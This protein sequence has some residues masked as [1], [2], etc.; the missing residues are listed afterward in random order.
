MGQ[1]SATFLSGVMRKNGGEADTAIEGSAR[2]FLDLPNSS[3]T[4][5][6]YITYHTTLKFCGYWVFSIFFGRS[7]CRQTRSLAVISSHKQGLATA[8]I[9]RTTGFDRGFIT[10]CLSKY[11]DSG[12]VDDASVRAGQGNFQRVWSGWWRR[13]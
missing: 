1:S 10:R 3:R 12:S 2:A 8:A 11:N 7:A 9:R 13:K 5:K 6:M 4:E